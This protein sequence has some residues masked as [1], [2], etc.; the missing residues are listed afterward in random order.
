MKKAYRQQTE[1][2]PD[3]RLIYSYKI[4]NNGEKYI[5]VGLTANIH[6]RDKQHRSTGGQIRNFCDGIGIDIIP[7]YIQE[8]DYLSEEEAA[9]KEGEILDRYIAEGYIPINKIKTGGLGN[10]PKKYTISE[11]AEIA[12]RYRSISGWKKGDSVSYTYAYKNGL[13]DEA[14]PHRTRRRRNSMTK[15]YI[16]S[17]IE[18]YPT[19]ITI[20]EFKER[21]RSVYATL[22]KNHVKYGIDMSKVL[23]R[24]KPASRKRLHITVDAVKERMR[25]YH[26]FDDFRINEVSMVSWCYTNHIKPRELWDAKFRPFP[27]YCETLPIPKTVLCYGLDVILVREYSNPEELKKHN[28]NVKEV[29]DC[30][31]GLCD[32]HRGHIFHFKEN[33][34]KNE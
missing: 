22:S 18:S 28:F 9:V 29:I 12:S 20:T 15:E 5:Y 11:L 16:L 23:K 3:G 10:E 32:T 21:E 27:I 6:Y 31:N 4:E 30:C 2:M 7:P 33:S 19:D 24:F 8:T 13:I 25:K 17:V 1:D 14:F 26:K 34:N